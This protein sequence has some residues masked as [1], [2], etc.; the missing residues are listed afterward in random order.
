MKHLVATSIAAHSVPC[1]PPQPLFSISQGL[2]TRKTWSTRTACNDQHSSLLQPLPGPPK[3]GSYALSNRNACDLREA[4]FSRRPVKDEFRPRASP[5]SQESF[6]TVF[7]TEIYIWLFLS[8]DM[9]FCFQGTK[10]RNSTKICQHVQ[11]I[12]LCY[13]VYK[14]PL[15]SP[16]VNFAFKGQNGTQRKSM[17]DKNHETCAKN[18]RDR[19]KWS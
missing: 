4:L 18:H 6:L 16:D 19:R 2:Y 15:F 17:N 14:R 3:C 10:K 12:S 13:K 5:S 7:V 11:K 9:S 1:F 8:P